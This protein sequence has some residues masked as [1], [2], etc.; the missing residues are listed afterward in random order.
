M[1][2]YKFTTSF[3]PLVL[4]FQYLT[5]L[6]DLAEVHD[7][8]RFQVTQWCRIKS[9]TLSESELKVVCTGFGENESG[10]HRFRGRWRFDLGFASNQKVKDVWHL[11][12]SPQC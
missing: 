1:A 4:F 10:K 12:S 11:L 6:L 7:F 2:V 9:I 8:I 5:E 3:N